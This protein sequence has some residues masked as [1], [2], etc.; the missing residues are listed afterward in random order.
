MRNQFSTTKHFIK[1]LCCFCYLMFNIKCWCQ[2]N[3]VPNASFEQFTDCPNNSSFA[4][5]KFGKPNIWYKPDQRTA[6]YFNRCTNNQPRDGVPYNFLGGGINY[7]QPR[8]GDAYLAM[9]YYNQ[10]GNNYIQTRFNDSLKAGKK[11]Y[12]EYYVSL[13]NTML[14]GCDNIAML[15]TKQVIYADTTNYPSLLQANPQIV[16]YGNPIVTDTMGWVKISGIFTAQGGEQYLTLGNFK[17]ASQTQFIQIAPFGTGYNGAAYY[18]DDV[19]VYNLDSFNLKADAGRDT[20]ITVGDSVFIGSYTNGIDTLQWQ[21]QSTS[22]VI[23]T[24]APGFWVKPLTHTCYVLTQTV[25]GYTSSDTVCVTVQPLPLTMVQY[26]LLLVNEKQ[27]LNN[28]HTANEVNVSHYQIQRSVDSRNFETIGTA[29]AKNWAS[30]EYS[31]VDELK[32]KDQQP[33]TLY[34]R[35]VG[36][37]KDGKKTFSVV[38]S[39]ELKVKSG[40]GISIYP[41]PVKEVINIYSQKGI[42]ELSLYNTLGQLKK[43]E[44]FSSSTNTILWRIEEA[45]GVYLIK[46]KTLDNTNHYQKIVVE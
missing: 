46:V 24:Q 16:S 25:N 26:Q 29:A 4:T 41:N 33:K 44:K 2:M 17:L 34:Y 32:V 45:K 42:K 30:N 10:N 35:I 31:F 18:V 12:G 20:T 11:Y 5:G 19:A 38:K 7:Q 1:V 27:V 39:L 3:L 37:D 22:A 8:T 43:Q 23:N 15:F 40:D 21:N 14:K 28:W 13:A 36:V 9:F 6:A